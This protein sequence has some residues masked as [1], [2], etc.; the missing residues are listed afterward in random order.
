ME[1]KR[2]PSV[3]DDVDVKVM[4]AA[5]HEAGHIVI[6]AT[7]KLRLRPEGLG[8]DLRGEGLACYCK[9]PDDSDLSRERVIVATFAGYYAERRFC[10]ERGYPAS[11]PDQWFL[12]S[13]DGLE[14]REVI[15]E[16]SDEYLANENVPT[17]QRNLQSRSEQLVEEHWVAIAALAAALLAKEPEPLMP[18]KSGGV[19]SQERTARYLS[20]QEMVGTLRLST[21]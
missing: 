17:I 3:P 13:L 10:E 19:W 5:H 7:Q 11:A 21:A 18:L 8:V 20:G 1:K 16:L 15:S 4:R 6:A 12:H 2:N 9:R 14:A